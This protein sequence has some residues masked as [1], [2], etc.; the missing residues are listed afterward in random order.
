[1]KT[2]FVQTFGCQ[3]NEYDSERIAHR[4]ESLG[5]TL[6]TDIFSSDLALINTCS[7][8]A[9]PEQKTASLLGKL[10]QNRYKTGQPLFIGV[11]GCMAQ[12]KGGE[13]IKRFRNVD[14][15]LGTDRIDKLEVVLKELLN[16]KKFVDTSE[17][18]VFFVEPFKRRQGAVTAKITIMKG[19]NNFC[20]YCIVPYVRG[21]EVC[22][23]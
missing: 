3:M 4:L 21:R 14:F 18:G 16:G 5:L 7:V 13:L 15:V 10:R 12:D 11:M 2:F 20:S 19:C 8:R 23:N 9:K 17:G 6:C 1:M 22:R